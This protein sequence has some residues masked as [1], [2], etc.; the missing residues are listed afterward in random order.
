MN[1]HPS[2]LPKYRGSAP[3]QWAVLNGD[4]ETGVST[5]YISE[6]MDAGDIIL[7]EKV[8]IGEYETTGELWD[9]VSVLGGKLLTKTLSMLENGTSTRTPQGEEYT[10][11]SMIQK[12]MAKIDWEN[13]SKEK[14]KNLVR[15][16]NPFLGAYSLLDNKK[17]KFWQVRIVESLDDVS[18]ENVQNA[19]PGEVLLANDK[20]GLYVKAKDGI[21]S[22]L[23]LQG[24]NARK[25]SICDFLRGNKIEAGNKFE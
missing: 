15:G 8:E 9:R 12:E 7:Q 11:A 1:V 6:K 23:E 25:M 22:V 4:K 19:K 2:L 16:L 14:I 13:F 21:I 24:E 3:I 18:V 17:I 5:M 20:K 10:E